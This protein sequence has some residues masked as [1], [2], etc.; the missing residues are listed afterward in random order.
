M[1]SG[2]PHENED[3]ETNIR[4]CYRDQSKIGI[5]NNVA[6]AWNHS[7][8]WRCMKRG[9][10]KPPSGE[11]AERIKSDLGGYEKFIEEFKNAGVTQFG[12]GWAWRYSSELL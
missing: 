8:F 9:G 12:S 3:S 4:K 1:I 10:G 7:F 5:F 11:I 6:Q 2:T